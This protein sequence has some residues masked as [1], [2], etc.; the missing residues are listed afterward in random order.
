[1]RHSAVSTPAGDL[2]P[3][4]LSAG[5]GVDDHLPPLVAQPAIRAPS[6]GG[7]KAEAAGQE[8]TFRMI[9]VHGGAGT[10]LLYQW[11]L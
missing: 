4:F 11:E 1:M 2:I 8:V 7:R 3:L 10:F 5:G 6:R 9:R